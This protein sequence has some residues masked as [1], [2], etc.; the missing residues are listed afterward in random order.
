MKNNNKAETLISILIWIVIIVII[1]FWTMKMIEYDKQKSI[2]YNKT[3]EI[4]MLETNANN[5]IKKIDTSVFNKNE[6][7]YLY[8]TGSQILAYSWTNNDYL[9]YINANWD[10]VTNT[11]I[12]KWNVYTRTF[13]IWSWTFLY[14]V[15][16]TTIKELI[17]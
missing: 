5:L 16:N 6:I 15:I 7:F 17:K 3:N 1:A 2:D 4:F 13:I 9:K 8:K 14:P 12:Y 11:W 10:L